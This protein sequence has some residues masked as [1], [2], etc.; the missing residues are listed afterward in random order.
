M[1]G[2]FE[3]V[4]R[5]PLIVL[6]GAHNP[7]GARAAAVTLG[8]FHTGGG[9]V[10][11]VGMSAERDP[12]EMLEALGAGSSRLVV[13]T[14]AATPRAMPVEVVAAAGRTLGCQVEVVADVA[15]AVARGV[16][17]AGPEDV[18]FV[19]GSL[20]VVGTARAVLLGGH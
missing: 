10:L 6:D 20:Y 4:G 18:V 8:D 16:A 5:S 11:V 2:R 15:G 7:A 17:R 13:A 14:E 12:I 1:P 9:V 3:I 19:T